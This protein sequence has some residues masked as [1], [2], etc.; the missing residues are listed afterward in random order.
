MVTHRITH[1]PPQ[2]VYLP[3]SHLEDPPTFGFAHPGGSNLGWSPLIIKDFSRLTVCNESNTSRPGKR[4]K[5][6]AMS[7]RHASD[8]AEDGGRVSK[9][10]KM[11]VSMVLTMV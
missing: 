2:R 8:S 5:S 1:G 7:K 3:P 10:A 11:E 9:H 4:R 6:L